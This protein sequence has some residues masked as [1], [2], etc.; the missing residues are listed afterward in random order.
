[1][2]VKAISGRQVVIAHMS[3]PTPPRYFI[4][5]DV[6]RVPSSFGLSEPAAALKFRSQS[7]SLGRGV[8]RFS[9]SGTLFIHVARYLAIYV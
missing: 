9:E 8:G 2:L 5:M 6:S 7:T 3:S 4:C 1:M